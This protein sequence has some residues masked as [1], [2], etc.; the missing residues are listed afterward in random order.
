MG[1]DRV[2]LHVAMLSKTCDDCIELNALRATTMQAVDNCRLS[3]TRFLEKVRMYER[4]LR[5]QGTGNL[6]RDMGEEDPVA[7]LEE[8]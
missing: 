3:L 5:E 1:P 8:G 6:L 4:S 2:L 7:N